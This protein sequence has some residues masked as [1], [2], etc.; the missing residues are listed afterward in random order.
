MDSGE[1]ILD[2]AKIYSCCSL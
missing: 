1:H 2:H